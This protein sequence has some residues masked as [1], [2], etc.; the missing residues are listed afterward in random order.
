[1]NARVI[2]INIFPGTKVNS[3]NNLLG[4]SCD[5]KFKEYDIPVK[6]LIFLAL[7]PV[8]SLSF[9]CCF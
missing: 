9:A 7:L 5:I 3:F 1:M 4:L 2:V 6:H 8:N